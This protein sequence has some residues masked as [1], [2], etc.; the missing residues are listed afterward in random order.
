M[1]IGI[2]GLGLIGG[3]LAK[4]VKLHTKHE[5]LGYDISEEEMRRAEL[6]EAID[7]RLTEATL[8]ECDIVL[9]ALYPQAIVNYI[10]E[11]ADRFKAG[12]LVIDCGGVKQSVTDELAETVTGRPWHFIGG[13]PMAGREYS[14]FRHAQDDLF[15]QASMILTPDESISLDVRS[16][17]KDF[18][19]SIGFGRVVFTTPEVH[20]EM[21]AYTSQLA[22]IISNVYIRSDLAMKHKGFSANSFQDMTR[23]ARLN[24]QMW[25]ELFLLNKEPLT[26]E[27]DGLIARLSSVRDAIAAGDEA[28]LTKLLNE[29]H[30]R[31]E[32]LDS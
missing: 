12:A 10:Q 9:V 14:G 5:I 13:H 16:F 22:H 27:L 17:A 2:V 24:A 25:T 4:A 29:G 32:L 23:V 18:F 21:I 30:E 26:A 3:S 15:E 31:K 7:G 8:P 28:R 11:N 1:K 19:L 20:D 6:T